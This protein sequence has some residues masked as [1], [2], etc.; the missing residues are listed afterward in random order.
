MISLGV[1]MR[2][3]F[4]DGAPQRRLADEDHAIEALVFDGAYE[5]LGVGAG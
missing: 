1:V 2:H 3:E 5:P 4:T